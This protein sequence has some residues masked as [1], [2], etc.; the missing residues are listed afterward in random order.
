MWK[1]APRPCPRTNGRANVASLMAATKGRVGTEHVESLEREPQSAQVIERYVFPSNAP[2]SVFA[3]SQ[4]C[5]AATPNLTSAARAVLSSIAGNS[6]SQ[7]NTF[8]ALANACAGTD[9]APTSVLPGKSLLHLRLQPVEQVR[10]QTLNSREWVFPSS[11]A[12][13]E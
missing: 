2:V 8:S 6:P 5:M 13:S 10:G 4:A 9:I 1:R 3:S 12:K 11:S 7:R